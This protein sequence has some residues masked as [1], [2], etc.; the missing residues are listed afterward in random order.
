MV[1]FF[2]KRSVLIFLTIAV[3]L[4]FAS[5]AGGK[6]AANTTWSLVKLVS[7]GDPKEN[8]V[9]EIVEAKN[10]GEP[11]E[12]TTSCSAGTS[13]DLN[14]SLTSGG[15]LGAGTVT[16]EGTIGT[17][18]GIGQESGE[19]VRLPTPPDGLI[20]IYTVSKTYQI[21]T[22]QAMARS[23]EGDEQPVNF[24]FHARCSIDIVNK[25]QTNCSG[26]DSLTNSSTPLSSNTSITNFRVQQMSDNQIKVTVDYVYNGDHGN[27]VNLGIYVL[28]D[29]EKMPWFGWDSAVI[30]TGKGTVSTRIYY[31]Y[32]DPPQTTT[33][34]KIIVTL[35]ANDDPAFFEET[36]DYQMVWNLA[37]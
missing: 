32:K 27:D 14:V 26:A 6:S 36:F 5:C 8:S 20:Y 33:T 34:E 2:P 17:T 1:N 12:K 30:S 25:E 28:H 18:L 23:S 10:C 11:I 31:G 7:V 21:V 29:G 37:Q 16:I 15:S 24:D 35:Y 19:S 9:T 4:G 3:S 22:G 13:N